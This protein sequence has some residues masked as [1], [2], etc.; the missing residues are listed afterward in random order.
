LLGEVEGEY[1]EAD[2]AINDILRSL[3][4]LTGYA[5]GA[6]HGALLT[7]R[8]CCAWI[9]RCLAFVVRFLRCVDTVYSLKHDTRPSWTRRR[10]ATHRHVP[11]EPIGCSIAAQDPQFLYR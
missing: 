7:V 2:G 5:D 10:H 4:R 1:M 3:L 9:D 11:L 6:D 8:W